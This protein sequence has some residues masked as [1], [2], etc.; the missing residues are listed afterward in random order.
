VGVIGN[1]FGWGGHQIQDKAM[2]QIH[3]SI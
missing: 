3:T 1:F 2:Q